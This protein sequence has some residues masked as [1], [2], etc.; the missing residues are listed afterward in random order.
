MLT[1]RETLAQTK[2]HLDLKND[3][4]RETTLSGNEVINSMK[5]AKEAGFLVT[6]FYVGLYDRYLSVERVANRVSLGGHDI[7]FDALMRRYEKSLTNAA[8]VAAIAGK[9]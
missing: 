1:G 2:N 8:R 7:P 4:T 3:F 6:L 5:Q 9:A